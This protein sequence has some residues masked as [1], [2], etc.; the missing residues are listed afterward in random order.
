MFFPKSP[1][2]MIYCWLLQSKT[3]PEIFFLSFNKNNINSILN[4]SNI[5]F[6]QQLTSSRNVAATLLFHYAATWLLTCL[7]LKQLAWGYSRC[8]RQLAHT[9]MS[10]YCSMNTCTPRHTRA[11]F[12]C[13]VAV[14]KQKFSPFCVSPTHAW[15]WETRKWAVE[16]S[17][18]T[19]GELIGL[20]W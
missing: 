9:R 10:T 19:L 4:Y 12:V 1:C 13:L 18:L 3:S 16:G 17:N 20:P 14:V 7:N 11:P 15:K 2:K 5:P 6:D 8:Q